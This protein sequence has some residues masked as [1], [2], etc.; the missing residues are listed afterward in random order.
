M[1]PTFYT[2]SQL[3]KTLIETYGPQDWW[4]GD[5]P[6][7]IMVG[8]VLTQNTSWNNVAIAIANVRSRDLL[9]LDALLS[10]TPEEVKAAIRPAGFH[11]VKYDRLT[12]LLHFVTTGGGIDSLMR[13]PTETL[14]PA[15]LEVRGVGPETADSIL[16]YVFGRPA[17]VVDKYT[18]RLLTRLGH[19]WAT[20]APY[21]A[22]QEWFVDGLEPDATL[23]GE[24]HAL[25]VQH[26]KA[27]CR[28]RPFCPGCPLEGCCQQAR[29]QMT[30]DN[31]MQP[32]D[33]P[34]V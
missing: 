34:H 31:A 5:S 24:Y 14:G 19:A 7:E 27:H 29:S 8:A 12:A 30:A 32:P 25:I 9:T 28:A 20:A 10:A 1:T 4:P 11:N 13:W 15:L 21:K 23:Y 33:Q 18:R 17:F 22:V 16:L 3:Y 6:L 2:A 26:G